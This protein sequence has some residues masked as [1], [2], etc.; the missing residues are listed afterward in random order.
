M[1][2]S[3]ECLGFCRN[4][5]GGFLALLGYTVGYIVDKETVEAHGGVVADTENEW[6]KE[7]PCGTG[8]Y[9]LDH[10]T[11]E[12]EV[13]LVKNEDYWG[14]WEEKHVDKVIIKYAN[15]TTRTQ[16]LKNG[17]ADFA[18]IPYENL[19]DVENEEGI[20]VQPYDSY[21]VV[22]AILNT[23]SNNAYMA[24]AEVRQALSYTFNYQSA[25]DDAYLGYMSRLPG[26]IPIGMPYDTTQNNGVPIYDYDLAEAETILG[27]A[28]YT[29]NDDGY[30]FNATTFRIF[31]NTGNA[32]RLKMSLS[33]QQELTELGIIS[34]VTTEEWPQLLHRMFT[35]SD[36]DIIFM[37]WGPDYND[38]D[39]Y[40]APFV[41]SADIGQDT[42]NT[43]WKNETVDQMILKAKYTTDP[44]ERRDAYQ[45]AFDI[46]IHDP[47]MIFIGQRQYVR[48]MRDW[49]KGYS[50]NPVREWY[51]YDYYK[52]LNH[53]PYT[54]SN[55][56]PTDGKT[57]VDKN[58][59]L[60]WSGGDPDSGDTVTYNVFF[61]T[62]NPPSKISSNQSG[63]SYDPGTMSYNTK[64]YWKIIAWDN[65]GA[66]AEGSIWS[67][68][69]EKQSTQPPYNPPYNPPPTNQDPVADASAGEPYQGFVGEE[70]T[71][72]GSLSY[73]PDDEGYIVSWYWSYGD[74]TNGT[75]ETTTHMYYYAGTYTV[76]LTVADNEDAKNTCETT[77]LISQPNRPPSKPSINGPTTG[78][79]NTEYIYTVI[80]TDSDNDTIKYS[81]IWGDQTSY[82][83]ESEFLPSGSVFT[84]NHIW[85]VAGKYTITV[86]TTDNKT[87]SETSKLT[88]LIDVVNVEDIGYFIDINGDGIYDSFHND[89]SNQ[90]SDVDYDDGKYLVDD[91]G[92][93][94]WDFTYG[95]DEGL[96]SYEKEETLT[97]GFGLILVVCALILVLFWKRKLSF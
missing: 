92:D 74:G 45:T 47:S 12:I 60:S 20:V 25:I 27:D 23:K 32:E 79:K 49:V 26:C 58:K 15:E 87:I 19:E 16:A 86:T 93:G 76:T 40:I 65:Y 94:E 46:Y 43:G 1:L 62:S 69:T 72:D 18:Y 39:D 97:P 56:S 50:Y 63:T 84:A 33:F 10:W 28:G 96:K 77:V 85:T 73:D 64:Y 3:L 81:F 37:G 80:S 8:P 57:N 7:N 29:K 83:T 71:F 41:G 21:D 11:H 67:F 90:D 61:G 91:N 36:W 68:N 42:Y 17:S 14:G 89:T 5:Y 38:P 9:K 4:V 22:L 2:R 6:M 24:E 31:Y 82:V 52:A 70:I 51:W 95:M 34:T 13:V 54:P 88:V 44:E 55:P 53:P 78:N 66:S 75:G 59:V 30:R 35:T 48:P